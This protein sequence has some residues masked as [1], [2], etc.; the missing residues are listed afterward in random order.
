M[1]ARQ[2]SRNVEKYRRQYSDWETR[3]PG[4]NCWMGSRVLREAMCKVIR[5]RRAILAREL[6]SVFLRNLRDTKHEN[7]RLRSSR[8]S[9]A[10]QIPAVSA[11]FRPA[12][13]AHNSQ[14]GGGPRYF[15]AHV[16]TGGFYPDG[17]FNS[18][19]SLF[20]RRFRS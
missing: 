11:K 7:L 15:L 12:V 6:T 3:Y 4:R 18:S 1:C 19:F 8:W 2:W 5:N 10:T 20:S 17:E 13:S 14:G 9:Y 16:S